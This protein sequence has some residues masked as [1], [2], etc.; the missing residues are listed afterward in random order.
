MG[1]LQYIHILDTKHNNKFN[2]LYKDWEERTEDKGGKKKGWKEEET[3]F[4][5]PR[6]TQR[7]LR[8]FNNLA[9]VWS[10]VISLGDV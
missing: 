9:S 8:E 6:A 10:V 3:A 4:Q 2:D 1:R 5:M 7:V